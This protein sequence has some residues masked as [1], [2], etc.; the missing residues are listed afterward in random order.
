MT[1]FK[2]LVDLGAQE[3]NLPQFV[4]D[5]VKWVAT[6][7]FGVD[8]EAMN[9]LKDADRLDIPILLIHGEDD[10]RV[11]IETSDKL[12]GLRPDIVTYRVY[13]DTSHGSAWNVDSERYERELRDFLLRVVK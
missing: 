5:T 8:W 6:L 2:A 11:P 3:R 12:A 10:T 13:P 1:D 9:Y 7:R 4:A